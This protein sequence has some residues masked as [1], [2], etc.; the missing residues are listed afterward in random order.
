MK[1]PIFMDYLKTGYFFTEQT[2][3]IKIGTISFNTLLPKRNK[4]FFYAGITKYSLPGSNIECRFSILWVSKPFLLL[5]VIEMFEKLK[6]C[7]SGEYG[8]W[9]KTS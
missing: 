3:L 7:R 2:L 9:S 6:I 5:E 4:F 1:C 8:G